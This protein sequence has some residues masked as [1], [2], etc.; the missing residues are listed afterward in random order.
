MTPPATHVNTTTP[1]EISAGLPTPSANPVN[2]PAT[3]TPQDQTAITASAQTATAPNAAAA[4]FSPRGSV[5]LDPS[6]T[7]SAA[8]NPRSCVTCR[9]RKVRCDKFM[10]C[11][12]CRKAH[13]QCVFPAPGRAPRRPRVRDP[14]APPKHTSEREIELMKRLRKLEGIVEDLSGQIEFETS[15]HPS[16]S[17]G[18]S[19]EAATDGGAVPGGNT[20]ERDRRPPAASPFGG[21]MP[22]GGSPSDIARM[23]KPTPPGDSTSGP[24]FRGA[25]GEVQREL[26][27][28]VLNESGKTRYVSNALWTKLND[29][30]NALRAETQ[31]LTDE[32]SDDSEDDGSP[33]GT[34]Y[35]SYT[36]NGDHHGFM[37]GYKSSEVDLSKLHPLPSQ[38]PFMWQVYV[39]NVDPLVKIL[40]VPTMNKIIRDC[41]NSMNNLSPGTEAL[42][43]SIYFGSITSMEEDEVKLNFGVEKATLVNKHRFATEQALAKANFLT[44]S[45]LVVVQAFTLYLVLVRRYDNTR[46]SWTLTGLAIRIAQSLG[47]H[48]EGT[49]FAELKPFDV[50]MRRRLWWTLCLLDLRSAED[51]GTELTILEG[52]HDTR[53]PLNVNDSDLSPSMTDFPLERQGVTDMSFSLVRFEV[54][55]LA[56]KMHPAASAISPN[57]HDLHVTPQEREDWIVEAYGRIEEKYLKGTTNKDSNPLHWVASIIARV[58]MAKLSL[59]IYQPTI[60]ERDGPELSQKIRDR[61]FLSSVEVVEYIK[62]VDAEQRCRQWQW[63]FQTYSQWHTVAYLLLEICR[64]P[65]TSSAERGW[66][67]LNTMFSNPEPTFEHAKRIEHSAVWIPLRKLMLKA[68]RHRKAEIARLRNDPRE[69]ERLDVE[70]MNKAAPASF[71]HLPSSMRNTLAQER[72]RALV[73]REHLNKPKQPCWGDANFERPGTIGARPGEQQGQQQQLQQPPHQLQQ[74]ISKAQL[75][76]V[77]RAMEET[78]IDP[79][80]FWSAALSSG[81]T[82]TPSN[83]IAQAAF[84]SASLFGGGPAAALLRAQSEQAQQEQSAAGAG[85]F[86]PTAGSYNGATAVAQSTPADAGA[87]RDDH[88]PPWLWPTSTSNGWYTLTPDSGNA[89]AV[90]GPALDDVDVNM[91][92]EININWQN[93][94]ESIRGFEMDTGMGLRRTPFMG[95]RL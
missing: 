34:V 30:L 60:L 44:T 39:E 24:L 36:D 10:P 86:P 47:L 74:Q 51:Q 83:E 37:L 13:I 72:W 56:R 31:K 52:A 63:H 53:L 57:P 4:P 73:G 8:L 43:F 61:L 85:T 23:G 89:A 1:M 92:E 67:A 76:Q 90:K 32:E 59:I 50:E 29:E 48:R 81:V 87:V 38:I 82:E 78:T 26:G 71:Q 80:I 45:E 66:M 17:V 70:E 54:C 58:I 95:G 19:P 21:N 65:W 88:P 27:R 33:C 22:G 79:E 62:I 77:D 3:S 46:F 7:P 14:D 28:L 2:S 49:R 75:E 6:T 40:H 91:D 11:G 12:N 64:R 42:M 25:T 16:S 69:A 84:F 94:Q 18:T 68:E 35:H 93:W 55:S 9:R 15:R 5:T 20:M 41:R